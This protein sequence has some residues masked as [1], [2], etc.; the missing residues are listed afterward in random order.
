MR[1]C[2][3]DSGSRGKI[4]RVPGGGKTLLFIVTSLPGTG[5]LE[6]RCPATLGGTHLL[7]AGRVPR[8]TSVTSPCQ[9]SQSWEDGLTMLLPLNPTDVTRGKVPSLARPNIVRLCQSVSVTD[10]SNVC[11]HDCDALI[12]LPSSVLYHPQPLP[13]SSEADPPIHENK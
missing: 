12:C 6:E 9:A 3:A 4:T 13:Q 1:F 2:D 7:V 11:L 5:V 8:R 10:G